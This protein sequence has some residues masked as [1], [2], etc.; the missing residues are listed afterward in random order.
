V[1]TPDPATLPGEMTIND[2]VLYFR[3]QATHRSYPVVGENRHLLGMVSRSDALRWQV[4]G[5]FRN[6]P[7]AEA[8]SDAS[9]PFSYPQ[10]PIGE[11]ADLMVETGV[12]RIPIID[13][14]THEVVGILSR[15]DLLKARSNGRKAELDRRKGG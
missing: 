8:I 5:E 12:G 7:L 2:V 9:Q 11:V 1:M 3:D 10:S 6:T 4:E 13:G 14:N 15:H